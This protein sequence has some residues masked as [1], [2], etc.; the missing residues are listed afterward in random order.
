MIQFCIA[1]YFFILFVCYRYSPKK[2]MGKVLIVQNKDYAGLT[3]EVK[4]E[5]ENLVKMK[6]TLNKMGFTD[7]CIE[8]HENQTKSQ[9][10]QLLQNS[11][12]I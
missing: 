11:K 2:H 4:A 5:D 9:M 10:I 12:Y 6:E 3:R 8:V 1:R 7:A